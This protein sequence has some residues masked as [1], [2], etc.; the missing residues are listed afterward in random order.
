MATV[1]FSDIRGFSTLA[2]ELPARDVA[3]VARP[4]PGGHGR[5]GRGPR[6]DDRQVRGRCRHGGVRGARPLPDHAE[7]A[8]QCALAMQARQA[9]LNAARGERPGPPSETGIG[10]NTGTGHRRDGGGRRK[11]R[12]HG[13]RGRGQRGP[14]PPVRG[15]SRRDLRSPWC[16]RQGAADLERRRRAR[17]GGRPC[18]QPGSRDGRAAVEPSAVVGDL[19]RERSPLRAARSRRS[20]ARVLRDVL[21][22]LQAAEVHGGLDLLRV[23]AEP[24]RVDRDRDRRLAGLRSSAAASPGRRAAAVDPARQIPEILERSPCRAAAPRERGRLRRVPASTTSARR[25]LPRSRRAAAARRRG[26]SARAAAAP[27]PAPRRAAADAWSTTSRARAPRSAG[28]CEAPARPATR[29]RSRCS[30]GDSGSPDDPEGR[31]AE[32]LAL[33]ADGHPAGPPTPGAPSSRR[34]NRRRREPDSLRRPRPRPGGARPDPQP[35]RRAP[36]PVPSPTARHP[37]EHVLGAYAP[38]IRSANSDEH[39]VRR[40]ALAEH[41][42]VGEPVGPRANRLERDGDDD[43]GDDGSGPSVAVPQQA[44][45]PRRRSDVDDGD[46]RGEHRDH[47]GLRITTSIS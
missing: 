11:A 2:E 39:L 45:R 46:E 3:V 21:Q 20:R 9:E 36:A 41:N 27:G 12:V 24:A 32:Q 35:H 6:G 22:R 26:C 47:D 23:P 16:R 8:L 17:R 13:P 38:A 7:R 18:S 10:V 31:R 34:S 42:P 1:L 5:G 43:R 14:A 30:P 25:S 37:R 29:G 33:V 40:R 44:P 4:P 15:G 28:R 19:E